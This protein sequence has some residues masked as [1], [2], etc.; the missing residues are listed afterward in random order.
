M[1]KLCHLLCFFIC[2]SLPAS[3]DRLKRLDRLQPDASIRE[4]TSNRVGRGL[5]CGSGKGKHHLFCYSRSTYPDY[6]FLHFHITKT[7]GTTLYRLFD[8]TNCGYS[9][10]SFNRTDKNRAYEIATSLW[11]DENRN[12]G[13]YTFEFESLPVLLKTM[14]RESTNPRPVKFLIF[15]RK[16]V[17][18][19]IS[20]F[21]HIRKYLK[22]SRCRSISDIITGHCKAFEFRNMQARFF[23]NFSDC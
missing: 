23:F 18:H 15:I 13:F 3:S 17:A 16:P 20:L 22:F 8:R 4:G 5:D 7:G 14:S 11:L 1:W 9:T 21:R 12:C 19:I 2:C 10:Y 6:F